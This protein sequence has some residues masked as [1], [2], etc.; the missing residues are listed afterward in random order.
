MV[1]GR[2]DRRAVPVLA[3][4]IWLTGVARRLARKPFS[5]MP[6]KKSSLLNRR[7]DG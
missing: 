1:L 2:A 7:V 4:A 5:V 6:D 3:R